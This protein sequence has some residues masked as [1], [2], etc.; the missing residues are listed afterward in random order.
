MN[1]QDQ[2]FASGSIR[3]NVPEHSQQIDIIYYDVQCFI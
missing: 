3:Y 1:T 2:L